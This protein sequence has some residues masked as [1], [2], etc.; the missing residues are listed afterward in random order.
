MTLSLW[1]LK[2]WLEEY[3]PTIQ[4][5][6]SAIEITGVRLYQPGMSMESYALYLGTS[7]A[8]FQ[9][10]G[11]NLVC[12][13]R[14]DFLRLETDDLFTVFNR[15]Q[16]A[17]SYYSRWYNRCAAEITKG[18]SLSA[19]L[20]IAQEVF[21]APLL[22]VD[23]AQIRVAQSTDLSSV[24]TPEDQESMAARRSIPEEKLKQFNQ[25]HKASIY[26][27]DIYVVPASFF[28]TKSYCMHIFT[29]EERLGTVILK[30][31]DKDP[32]PGT[33]Q[34]LK[35]FMPLVQE[36][37]LFNSENTSSFR[38]TSHFARALDGSPDA[39]PVLLR[40]LALFDWAADCRKQVYVAAAP[41][42][43][44][45]FD[46]HLNSQ[47]ANGGLGL[48]VIPYQDKVAILCNLDL[49]DYEDFSQNLL[50]ILQ[51]KRCFCASSFSFTDLSLFRKSYR[52]ALTALEHCPQAPGTLYRCQDVAMR[53]IVKTVQE[54]TAGTLL[55]PAV[56]AIKEY[57]R[58]HK[59]DYYETLFSYLKNERRHQQTAKELFIHRN[60][61]F[62]RLE[63]IQDL[64]PM[65]L[66]DTEE[67]FYLLFSFY[68]D[69]YAG[70]YQDPALLRLQ[71][72][73]R[74]G[75]HARPPDL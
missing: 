47:L 65:D 43:Q 72:E 12:R 68:Q 5:K 48:F 8:F 75:R 10:G 53:M 52:Q 34:L 18:G 14:S 51:K 46:T 44:V 58:Q 28:P 60:T 11:K 20:V 50:D 1:I 27:K 38:L 55:H 21:Q 70:A 7:D 66:E 41:N 39:L 36:W 42:G 9:D 25:V 74:P 32:S 56:A 33:L 35:L 3:A 63:K 17:F 67:R 26:C 49:L 45:E 40:Q 61:L 71:E 19:L 4:C 30:A 59:T 54:Y 13:H 2:D 15:I 31:P 62:L 57:D 69:R 6:N 24:L 73:E 22:I 29:H 37:I 16:D 23:A 64:W